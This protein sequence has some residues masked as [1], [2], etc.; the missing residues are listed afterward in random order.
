MKIGDLYR[1]LREI[2]HDLVWV[3][4]L[5]FDFVRKESSTIL[6][7]SEAEANLSERLIEM[8]KLKSIAEETTS[9]CLE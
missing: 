8:N 7:P 5:D 9:L 2:Q 3:H 6:D 1:E 4:N